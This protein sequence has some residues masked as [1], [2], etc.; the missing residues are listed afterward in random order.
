MET[1]PTRRR[2]Y[3]RRNSYRMMRQGQPAHMSTPSTGTDILLVRQP[4]KVMKHLF[5][6]QDTLVGQS[7]L[8]ELLG[9]LQRLTSFSAAIAMFECILAYLDMKYCLKA[10][11]DQWLS[12]ALRLCGVL[13]SVLLVACVLS[14]HMLRTKALHL[15]GSVY[16]PDP[17]YAM[18]TI[19][20][21]R[22]MILCELSICAL[23][24]PPGVNKDFPV[25]Q[26]GS[27]NTLTTPEVLMPFIFTRLYHVLRWLYYQSSLRSYRARFYM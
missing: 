12:D 18:W 25:Q 17:V 26:L 24:V 2:T 5:Q 19:R 21:I 20:P 10:D 8:N 27:R 14:F 16:A 3:R 23:I 4:S 13:C 7:H 9:K 22:W 15:E 1:A 6:T 11:A